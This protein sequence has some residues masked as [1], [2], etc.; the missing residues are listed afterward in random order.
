M[1]RVVY[2][3]I[4]FLWFYRIFSLVHYTLLNLSYLEDPQVVYMAS[5]G[6][7]PFNS[8]LSGVLSC[9]GTAVLAGK[10]TLHHSSLA[11]LDKRLI[12]HPFG[13]NRCSLSSHSGEQGKQGI[14]GKHFKLILHSSS[15]SG[16]RKKQNWMVLLSV[17]LQIE[18]FN[19]TPR[20]NFF[21]PLKLFELGG[22]RLG[23]CI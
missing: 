18:E 21:S 9:V 15:S 22:I 8:F 16:R 10:W 1:D 2:L 14:Q 17:Q 13:F 6:S 4:L 20:N 3:L 7:F 11:L 23:V 5:V 12:W 19:S